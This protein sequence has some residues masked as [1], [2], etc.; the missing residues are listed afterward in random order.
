MRASA[1][2]PSEFRF[3]ADTDR[4]YHYGEYTSGGGY[5]ASDTNRQILNLKKKPSAS[6]YELQHKARAVVYWGKVILTSTGLNL[7]SCSRTVTFV[8]MPCSKP[9]DHPDYDDRMSRVMRYV[10]KQT[11]NGLDVRELLVQTIARQAQHSGPRS[12]P[13][14]IAASLSINQEL[15]IPPI[16]S[17]IIVVDDV[18][19]RGASFAAAK[20][21]LE[22]VPGVQQ[23]YGLFLAK[24]V[25]PPIEWPVDPIDDLLA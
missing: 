7:E 14:D 15:L 9:A 19:T 1:L 4:C 3:L 8:P 20:S 12:E 13:G 2:N 5:K 22:D 17:T 11:P 10:S 24:T 21:L 16:R 25:H 23:V 18:I 6:D